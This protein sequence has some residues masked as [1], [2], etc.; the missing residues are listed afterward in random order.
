MQKFCLR[1]TYECYEKDSVSDLKDI[2]QIMFIIILNPV[3]FIFQSPA[4]HDITCPILINPSETDDSFLL[5]DAETAAQKFKYTKW[6]KSHIP[7]APV[8]FSKRQVS[9]PNSEVV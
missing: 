7:I 9:I 1:F 3:C 2:C 5:E 8:F 4:A 6:H